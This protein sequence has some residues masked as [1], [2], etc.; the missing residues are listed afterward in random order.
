MRALLTRAAA[1]AFLLFA[2]PLAAQAAPAL[3]EV[4]DTDSKVF[5]F[6]S[7]H[8]LP[9]ATQWRTPAFDATL[10]GAS[11][12]YFEADIGLFSQIFLAFQMVTSAVNASGVHWSDQLTAD[13]AT[14]VDTALRQ[15]GM[16]LESA[17]AYR[18]WFLTLLLQGRAITQS[19]ANM[20]AGVE[21]TVQRDLDRNRMAF[22][23]T[24]SQQIAIFSGMSDALQLRMLAG[25]AAQ[26]NLAPDMLLDMVEVWNSGDEA[27]MLEA[28]SSDPDISEAE[29]MKALLIDRNA[30]WI[31][32]IEAMLARN[33]QNLI[34][35]GAAHLV[36][37]TGVVELLRA[38]GYSVRRVQ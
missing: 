38:K 33:E 6:G 32:P 1:L 22:L 8:V 18:P 35:V 2:T 7:V 26:T 25:T 12:V 19:T 10:A 3:W 15:Q 14:A 23:E 37:D 27:K 28:V 36:G 11:K 30:S 17:Q 13:E 5:L 34:I 31:S 29:V 4:S 9:V 20:G 21:V 16:T 24:A